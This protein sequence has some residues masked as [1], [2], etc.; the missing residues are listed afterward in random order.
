[1]SP[2]RRR[3]P[4]PTSAAELGLLAE[5]T[6]ALGGTLDLGRLMGRL[7]ELAQSAVG[8]DA[9][10]VWLLE[11]GGAELALRGDVGFRRAEIVARIAHA[12]GRDVLGW[13]TTRPGPLV[14]RHLPADTVPEA[15]RWLEVE[16][17]RSFV[18]VP[19]IG[20]TASLGMLGLFRRGR[21]P[22]TDKELARAI[23]LCVPAPPA[24]LNAR[25]YADQLARAERTAVLLAI[26]ETLG[27]T[28]DLPAALDDIAQRAARALD[29]E[30]C[31]VLL[32]PGG[33]APAD[34]TLGDAE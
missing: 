1:M 12:P 27:A 17:A 4:A 26:A 25:L 8:A 19:L 13:I 32:W 2:G 6:R 14:L 33:V 15:R 10:G 3:G 16:E 22:F 29:A 21:R 30:R 5:G 18:G 28:S 24:I 23:A 20:E 34:A 9:A 7:T 31:V 11:R